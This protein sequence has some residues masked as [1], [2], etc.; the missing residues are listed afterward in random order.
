MAN[1]TEARPSPSLLRTGRFGALSGA[2][3]DKDKARAG[4]KL[5]SKKGS[6][7]AEDHKHV[8]KRVHVEGKV[9]LRSPPEEEDKLA[10]EFVKVVASIVT[11]ART[12]DDSFVLVSK[13]DGKHPW[14]SQPSQVD[15]NHAIL[16]RHVTTAS[17]AEF[18]RQK[19]W[20][21]M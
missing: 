4:D 8:H 18:R 1:D 10:D 19:P 14:I 13:V 3:N 6:V 11:N 5:K 12:V 9:R 2:P 16:G 21:N 20:G 17:N 7:V 15:F